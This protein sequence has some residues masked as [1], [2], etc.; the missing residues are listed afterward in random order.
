M[1]PQRKRIYTR[2]ST[3]TLALGG[4]LAASV[5]IAAPHPDGR[6]HGHH[7]QQDP[8]FTDRGDTLRATGVVRGVDDRRDARVEI[9]AEA[10]VRV[11]CRRRGGGH[12]HGHGHGGGSFTKTIDIDV[13]GSKYYNRRSIYGNR[14]DYSVQTDRIYNI[15]HYYGDLCPRNYD[16]RVQSVRFSSAKVE[17]RQGNREVM[18]WLCSF[19][20]D[21]RN[22]SVPRD[23]V[24]CYRL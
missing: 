7:R 13:D 20:R 1:T 18:T 17:V 15:E 23:N 14:L 16:A 22:G 6:G 5:A 8:R 24:D 2:I 12:G 9:E 10:R 21:T 19:D 3:V 11:E 4:L